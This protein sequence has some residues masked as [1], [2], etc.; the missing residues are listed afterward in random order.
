MNIVRHILLI[1]DFVD[2][3]DVLNI[4]ATCKRAREIANKYWKQEFIKI[5]KIYPNV[6]TNSITIRQMCIRYYLLFGKN[7]QY[8]ISYRNNYLVLE[9][10][11]YVLNIQYDTNIKVL[12]HTNFAQVEFYNA[13]NDTNSN[14]ILQ[15]GSSYYCENN[16]FISNSD[17]ECDVFRNIRNTK[18]SRLV[19]KGRFRKIFAFTSPTIQAKIRCNSEVKVSIKPLIEKYIYI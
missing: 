17:S 8:K 5:Y 3:K 14:A 13:I 1:M 9:K 18:I 12:S 10:G 6:F 16:K 4:S 7:Y 15:I 19:V 11:E 2:F